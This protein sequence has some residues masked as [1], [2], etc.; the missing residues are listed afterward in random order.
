LVKKGE[1]EEV[2]VVEEER[3]AAVRGM[4]AVQLQVT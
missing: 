3:C 4:H 2:V 1:E